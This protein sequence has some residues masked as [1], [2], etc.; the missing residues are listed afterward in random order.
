MVTLLSVKCSEMPEHSFSNCDSVYCN[1]TIDVKSLCLSCLADSDLV[2]LVLRWLSLLCATPRAPQLAN[3]ILE[4]NRKTCK[5][6][7]VEV[8]YSVHHPISTLYK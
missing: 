5:T 1:K 2:S 4:V 8:L 6:W 7:K 3:D